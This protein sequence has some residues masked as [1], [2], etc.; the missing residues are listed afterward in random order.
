MMRKIAYFWIVFFALVLNGCSLGDDASNFHF[1]ALRITDAELPDSFELNETYEINVHYVL[2]NGC[3]SFEGFD[4]VRED[5]TVRNVTAIGSVRTD[6]NLC[7]Q[8]I[9]EGETSFSFVVLYDQPYVFRFF[10]GE[11]DNGEREYLE[12][13]VPVIRIN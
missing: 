8:A 6:E 1:E 5:T 9:I 10:Q 11:N 4:F 3:T 7:T 12:I 2:Q 13:T